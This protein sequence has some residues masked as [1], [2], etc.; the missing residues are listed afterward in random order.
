MPRGS[1]L[2][3]YHIGAFDSDSEVNAFIVSQGWYAFNQVAQPARLPVGGI[4]Y[5]NRTDGLLYMYSNN[6][7]QAVGGA[8]PTQVALNTAAIADFA[9]ELVTE[10]IEVTGDE[11]VRLTGDALCWEDLRTSGNWRK[12]G[13]DEPAEVVFRESRVFAFDNDE[14]LGF[15]TQMSHMWAEGTDVHVH[16][17]WTP[18]GRGVTE[19]GKTVAWKLDI[20]VADIYGVFPSVTTYDLTDTCDGTDDKHQ[21]AEATVVMSMTGKHISNVLIGRIYR[22]ST[23]T[24]VGTGTNC[25]ILLEMDFHYQINTFGSEA[26]YSKL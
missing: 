26:E 10:Q 5:Y 6:A 23:D 19:S 16:L 3:P 15:T 25:P 14:E 13:T 12:R 17:H 11:A 2:N 22:D 18:A 21:L 8:N 24:W 1:N 9:D 20:A 7:W 4:T